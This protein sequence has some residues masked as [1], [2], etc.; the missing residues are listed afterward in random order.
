[1]VKNSPQPVNSR[2][3]AIV[4]CH[5]ELT[6][7]LSSNPQYKAVAG[8]ERETVV[9]KTKEIDVNI[10]ALVWSSTQTGE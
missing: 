7:M 4:S 5:Q 10:L 2:V 3:V 1:M 8:S 6:M 9:R